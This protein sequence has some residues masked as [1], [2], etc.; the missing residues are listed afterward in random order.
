VQ[1]KWRGAAT[2]KQVSEA[3]PPY[4]ACH[5]NICIPLHVAEEIV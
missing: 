5:K 4:I 1:W 2:T 3:G